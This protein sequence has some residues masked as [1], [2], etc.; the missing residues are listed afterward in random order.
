M[1][2][3]FSTNEF[4]EKSKAV[5][6][7]KF[8]YEKCVYINRRTKVELH[9]RACSE[10]FLATPQN[11][12]R[13]SHGCPECGRRKGVESRRS[14]TE[15]FA[16]KAI[17]IHGSKY[18]YGKSIYVGT[19]DKVIITCPEHGDFEQ[20]PHSHLQ[21]QGCPICST[22]GFKVHK[23]GI[24]Y[25]LSVLGGTAYKIGIT[26]ASVEKRFLHDDMDIIKVVK[27]WKFADGN[28]CYQKEQDIIK[29]F[30]EFKYRGDPLLKNGNSELF[31]V[32]ILNLDGLP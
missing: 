6:G 31:S 4:I 2:K 30:T 8:T 20:R 11:H 13:R 14:N 15:E 26:N 28:E 17:A 29:E 5:H 12:I 23:P 9:C 3:K 7:D 27:V 19:D 18:T 1:G 32:D 10:Y 21:G 22:R 16:S 25:Y 24:M